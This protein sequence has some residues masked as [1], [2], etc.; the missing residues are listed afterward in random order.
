LAAIKGL[1]ALDTLLKKYAGQLPDEVNMELS[2][3]AEDIARTARTIAPVGVTGLLRSKIIVNHAPFIHEVVADT[4]YA[5]FVEF[6]TGKKVKI[7]AG[8]EQY[9]AQFKGPTNR[10]N[11]NDFRKSLAEWVRR[12]G[13]T[14]NA[15]GAG[16]DDDRYIAY[17][18]SIRILQ[19]G[20]KAQPFFFRSADANY[21]KIIARVE[22]VLKIK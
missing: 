14:G 11:I 21:P 6:G 13:I 7:P 16:S 15:R 17:W 9:A 18:M 20:I 22:E 5:P 1:E 2:A 19:N 3:G 4:D 12:K 8:L 10:G